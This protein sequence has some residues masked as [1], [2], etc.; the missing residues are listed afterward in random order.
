M[1]Q[2]KKDDDI[3]QR[4]KELEKEEREHRKAPAGQSGS[5]PD[6]GTLPRVVLVSE[7]GD[8]VRGRSDDDALTNQFARVV[9]G[10]NVGRYGVFTKTLSIGED[11]YPDKVLLH[12]RDDRDE[13]LEVDYADLRPAKAGGR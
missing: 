5:T 3:E 4:A 10:D 11:G 1:P 12:T 6:A 9:A 13:D 7:A 8:V 2:A